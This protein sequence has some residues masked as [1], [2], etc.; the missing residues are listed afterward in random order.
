MAFSFVCNVSVFIFRV[1]R[2]LYLGSLLTMKEEILFYFIMRV[3]R[4]LMPFM[5]ILFFCLIL[6]EG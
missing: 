6:R 2:V 4:A 3:F 5:Y 1:H